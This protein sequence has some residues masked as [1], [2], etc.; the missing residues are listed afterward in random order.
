MIRALHLLRG[1]G[2]FIRAPFRVSWI[3]VP[4]GF[5]LFVL[6]ITASN[7]IW[8]RFELPKCG[9]D[10][11]EFSPTGQILAWR[12]ERPRRYECVLK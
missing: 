11:I 4:L 7:A 10:A 3:G 8:P 12:F 9:M 2:Y 6:L 1:V 5:A